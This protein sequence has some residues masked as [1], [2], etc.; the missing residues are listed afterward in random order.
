[1][2]TWLIILV[3]VIVVVNVA[4]VF[5]VSGSRKLNR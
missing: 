5:V 2:P 3:V 1:M 4:T